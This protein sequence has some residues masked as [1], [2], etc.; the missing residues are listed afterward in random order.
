VT[1]PGDP[2]IGAEC[3]AAFG[4]E[5]SSVMPTKEAQATK[6]QPK[7]VAVDDREQARKALHKALQM[8]ID[9]RQ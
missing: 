7:Q 4:L 8:S 9:T 5:G 1:R 3:F 6:Q 2:G